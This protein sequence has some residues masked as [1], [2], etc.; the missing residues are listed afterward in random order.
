MLPN[1]EDYEWTKKNPKFA[2]FNE[3]PR[4]LK[5]QVTILNFQNQKKKTINPF[6]TKPREKKS[7]KKIK[8]TQKRKAKKKYYK[9]RNK[10]VQIVWKLKYLSVSRGR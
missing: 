3:K 7:N 2:T 8:K 9:N 1:Y 4:N 6:A 10:L 5:I